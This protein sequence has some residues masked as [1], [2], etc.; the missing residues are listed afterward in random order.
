MSNR[1][2]ILFAIRNTGPRPEATRQA[3]GRLSQHAFLGLSEK[4]QSAALAVSD[5]PQRMAVVFHHER[6][7][8]EAPITADFEL[9][10]GLDETRPR[11]ESECVLGHGYVTLSFRRRTQQRPTNVSSREVHEAAMTRSSSIGD[12]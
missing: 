2:D 8:D 5:G 3:L 11:S 6:K 12:R 7:G 4:A 10:I 9:H 1:R